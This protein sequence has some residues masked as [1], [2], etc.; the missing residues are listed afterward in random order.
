MAQLG[1]QRAG[2]LLSDELIICTL[3]RPQEVERCLDSVAIQTRVPNAIRVV[4]ASTN[5]DTRSVVER[6]AAGALLGRLHY[7]LS[8]PGL[9]RQRNV[10][11][12]AGASDIVH[13]V[14]DDTVLHP[15]YLES[16]LQQFEQDEPGEILGVGGSIVNLT[17]HRVS[18]AKRAFMLD[19]PR[20]GRV[21]PSGR[22]PLAVDV[23]LVTDVDWLSGCTMSYRRA[24]FTVFSFN[25]RLE[26]Y[27]LG[28][29]VEFSYRVRQRGRLLVTPDARI[30]HLQ[31][32][33]NRMALPQYTY[34]EIVNRAQRV[35]SRIGCL[36]MRWFWWSV[37]GQLLA[38]SGAS[39]VGHP[40]QRA[41]LRKG[42]E[43]ALAVLRD[44]SESSG[45]GAGSVSQ[46]N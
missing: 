39:V 21:L 24:V 41:R 4:D 44:A 28:E 35:R 23:A 7:L 14:D 22:N 34:D 30:E 43:A 27:G 32:P 26:G 40:V 9:T 2:A 46:R 20:P 10:G 18:M 19:S 45:N 3:N 11:V 31:S 33:V 42:L 16:I 5:S 36:R 8:E 38:L 1:K 25:E 29:D 15:H 6:H 37:V 17:G 13:F 12:A